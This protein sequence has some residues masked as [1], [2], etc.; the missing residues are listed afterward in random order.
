MSFGE[1]IKTIRGKRP[2]ITFAKELGVGRNVLYNWEYNKGTPRGAALLK[3]YE[4]FSVNINWL[5]SGEGSPYMVG[6]QQSTSLEEKVV[7]MSAR[8]A[9]LEKK[10]AELTKN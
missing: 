7:V 6:D 4:K 1:R 8:V 2:Q 10:V 5:L 9:A 3:L